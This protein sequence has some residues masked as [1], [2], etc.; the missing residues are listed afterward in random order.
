[1]SDISIMLNLFK[2]EVEIALDDKR[3]VLAWRNQEDDEYDGFEVQEDTIKMYEFPENF[4]PI[5]DVASELFLEIYV[6]MLATR[7]EVSAYSL[8]Y[9]L[10]SCDIKLDGV[11]FL[12]P[13][14]DDDM[15]CELP[16]M[17]DDLYKIWTKYIND[18]RLKT[19]HIDDADSKDVLY[20]FLSLLNVE[21]L[22]FL[23]ERTT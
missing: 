1:M 12:P 7:Y 14:V 4:I 8:M 9:S 21:K 2:G 10:D 23:S 17:R 16:E 11:V 5:S 22:F 18:G 3:T 20:D 19:T 15:V 6:G 13:D